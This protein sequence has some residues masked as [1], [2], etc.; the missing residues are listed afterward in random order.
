MEKGNEKHGTSYF[1][2][3]LSVNHLLVHQSAVFCNNFH[4]FWKT[5]M[6]WE[7]NLNAFLLSSILFIILKSLSLNLEDYNTTYKWIVKEILS[8]SNNI[9]VQYV[10]FEYPCLKKWLAEALFLLSQIK[11]W[12]P[13]KRDWKEIP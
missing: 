5:R 13:R 1:K 8:Y 11:T 6:K 12:V 4:L 7:I 3:Y 9:P 2:E 10:G